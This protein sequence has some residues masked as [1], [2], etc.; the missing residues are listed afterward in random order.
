MLDIASLKA[1]DVLQAMVTG[2]LKSKNDPNFVLKMRTYGYVESGFCYGCA[3]TLTLVEMFGEGQSVSELMFDY[4]KAH[5]YRQ[6]FVY[7]HLSDVIPLESSSGQDSLPI[8]LKKIESLVD[9]VRL[10]D[11]SFLIKFL[12]GIDN[13]SFDDRWLLN[14]GNWEKCIPEIEA[15]IAEMIAAGY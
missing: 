15:T 2:L 11:V 12:T 1:S 4:V 9:S 14:D 3:A 7:A 5:A 8:D 13:E 6:N 10:G